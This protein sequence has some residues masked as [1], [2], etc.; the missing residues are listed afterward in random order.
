MTRV[1]V[2]K[3]SEKTYR[4]FF[5]PAFASVWVKRQE[6]F[7]QCIQENLEGY[8]VTYMVAYA[9]NLN[10]TQEDMLLSFYEYP[11]NNT[12]AYQIGSVK[13]KF[14][15]N[16]S[17]PK[18]SLTVDDFK[19]ILEGKKTNWQAVT[20]NTDQEQNQFP[21]DIQLYLYPSF[22]EITMDLKDILGLD[23]P[24]SG[25]TNLLTNQAEIINAVNSD[26]GGLGVVIET[27]G[28]LS[29][30]KYIEIQGGEEEWSLPII[31]HLANNTD[32]RLIYLTGCFQ[33][34]LTT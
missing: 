25:A 14:I 7:Q 12:K 34:V 15:V 32:D 17:N 6:D 11:I 4:L 9:P 20:V 3:H 30:I 13:I 19:Y 2:E 33:K 16:A 26:I 28:K 29:G 10:L 23:H 24:I 21:G 18:N 27:N 31:V 22:D 8:R 1:D 5:T